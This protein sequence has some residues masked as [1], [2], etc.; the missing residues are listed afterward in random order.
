MFDLM[1][2]NKNVIFGGGALSSEGKGYGFG[3]VNEKESLEA[4]ELCFEFGVHHFDTA[5]IYGFGESEKRLAK[6]FKGKRDKV[7][8]TNKSGVSWHDNGRV[9]MTNEPKVT[10][11]MLENSLRRLETEY[12]DHY[13][14]H[15]PDKKVDIRRPMEVLAKAKEQGKIKKIGLC[16]THL[17]DLNKA[18][19][20]EKIE[21][22]Q[23]E[24]NYFSSPSDQIKKYILENKIQFMGWG[25][26]DKGILTGRAHKERVYDKEDCRS[27]APWWKKSPLEK[28]FKQAENFINW[29]KTTEF[30]PVSFCLNKTFLW[31]EFS[32][33]IIGGK[34]VS[35]WKDIFQALEKLPPANLMNKAEEFF[36][37]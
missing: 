1:E 22:I 37:N 28:K 27:W 11:E 8:I 23:S 17:E 35:Q 19:E 2:N 31:G 15:W 5:P 16:N 9:N 6:F 14:I 20:I 4:L 30:S 12:I 34:N 7:F 25:T 33:P 26:L 18:S 10:R 13:L 29:G 36:E 32:C 24:L 3:L 21:I